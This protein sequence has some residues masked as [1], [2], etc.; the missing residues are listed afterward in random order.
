MLKKYKTK[1]HVRSKPNISA[2]VFWTIISLEDELWEKKIVEL[3]SGLS[4]WDSRVIDWLNMISS[5]NDLIKFWATLTEGQEDIL[6]A[7]ITTL[8]AA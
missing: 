8:Q 7:L 6:I 2:R 5:N 1:F 3:R 4:N